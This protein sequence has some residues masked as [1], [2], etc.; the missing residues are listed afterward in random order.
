MPAEVVPDHL[1][2]VALGEIDDFVRRGEVELAR[3]RLQGLGLELVLAGEAVELPRDQ[4][5]R[6]GVVELP[7][8]DRRP[9]EESAVHG[10]SQRL[11][12]LVG[13]GLPVGGQ[14]R[15]G[16]GREQEGGQEPA[17]GVP[18]LG[19]ILRGGRPPR[20]VFTCF[21]LS[22]YLS[23]FSRC[24]FN[25][26]FTLLAPDLGRAFALELVPVQLQLVLDGEFCCP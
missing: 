26:I 24:P 15:Q 4:L 12:R 22:R 6:R 2:V 18:P 10:V 17:H 19:G 9:D 3:L 8:H 23:A 14:G 21:A 1:H 25:V 13:G 20:V 7:G 16:Q 11:G 5:R